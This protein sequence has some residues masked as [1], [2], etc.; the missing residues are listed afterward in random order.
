MAGGS[1][2]REFIHP[3]LENC[4]ITVQQSQQKIKWFNVMVCGDDEQP[5]DVCPTCKSSG[6]HIPFSISHSIPQFFLE[7]HQAINHYFD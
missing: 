7:R 1:E 5:H 4:S 6:S 2:K 3:L